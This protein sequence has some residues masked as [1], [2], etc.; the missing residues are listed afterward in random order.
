MKMS[1]AEKKLKIAKEEL[2]NIIKICENIEKRGL[3]PFTVNIKE[4]LL[5]LRKTLEET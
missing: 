1:V 2:E 5:K 4:L 3:N